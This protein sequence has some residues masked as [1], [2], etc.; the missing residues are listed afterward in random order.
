MR[1]DELAEARGLAEQLS[2]T[3][4]DARAKA[5]ATA[6]QQQATRTKLQRLAEYEREREA[7][8]AELLEKDGIIDILRE[9][10]HARQ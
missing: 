1:H 6:E 7:L 2:M 9:H 5:E 10:V 3:V 4:D 8:M